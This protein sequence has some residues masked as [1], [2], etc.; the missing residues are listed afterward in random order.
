MTYYIYIDKAIKRL[1]H[2][3]QWDFD[4]TQTLLAALLALHTAMRIMPGDT[5]TPG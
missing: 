5:S 3:R 2:E 4:F 1:N